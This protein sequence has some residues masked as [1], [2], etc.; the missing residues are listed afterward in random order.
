M[1]FQ[2]PMHDAMMKRRREKRV[3]KIWDS[4]WK[5]TKWEGRSK[6]WGV[7]IRTVEVKRCYGVRKCWGII[8]N[9][10]LDSRIWVSLPLLLVSFK[11]GIPIPNATHQVAAEGIAGLCYFTTNALRVGETTRSE[12]WKRVNDEGSREGNMR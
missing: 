5:C 4:E 2:V 3:R 11:G 12:R 7:D 10:V 8:N 9:G 6:G 1:G